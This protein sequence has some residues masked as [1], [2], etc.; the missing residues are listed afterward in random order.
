MQPG[1]FAGRTAGG[2]PGMAAEDTWS[3]ALWSSGRQLLPPALSLA[4]APTICTG[5]PRWVLGASESRSQ[6]RTCLTLTV[7]VTEESRCLKLK[8]CRQGRPASRL[9][10]G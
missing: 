1:A 4:S 3:L 10:C 8:M 5:Q 2:P 6:T 9:L 7:R